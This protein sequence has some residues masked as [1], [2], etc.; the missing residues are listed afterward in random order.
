MVVFTNNQRVIVFTIGPIN[1]SQPDNACRLTTF[2][3]LLY[4]AV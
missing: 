4:Q 1:F 2:D 3:N